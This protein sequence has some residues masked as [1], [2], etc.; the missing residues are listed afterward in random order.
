MTS[1]SELV[2]A[3][4]DKKHR[5]LSFFNFKA[6]QGAL[7]QHDFSDRMIRASGFVRGTVKEAMGFPD[8][9]LLRRL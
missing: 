7:P 6:T 5:N 4:K 9:V 3:P 8:S 2:F 1:Q